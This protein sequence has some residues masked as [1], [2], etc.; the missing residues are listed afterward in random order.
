MFT[1]TRKILAA[2]IA[3]LLTVALFAA[4]PASAHVDGGYLGDVPRTSVAIQVDAE[5][6]AIY[7]YALK[8]EID[9]EKDKPVHAYGTA[10]LLY[11]NG[12]LY[13]Y[14]QVFDED[15]REPEEGKR[16]TSPWHTDSF[17][18]FINIPNNN[19]VND[20]MQYRVD[21]SGWPCVYNKVD[22]SAYGPEAVE[23][24]FTYAAKEVDGGYC[25]E[26]AI[27]VDAAGKDIGVNFQIND[28]HGA[29]RE[30][31]WAVVY[32]AA[33]KRGTNSWDVENYPYLSLGSYSEASESGLTVEATPT[34]APTADPNATEAPAKSSGKLSPAVIAAICAGVV[35]I[36]AAVVIA[37]VASKKKLK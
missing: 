9:C 28:I 24:Y 29:D 18:V 7:E 20:V 32:S 27:P 14:G 4:V 22:L 11:S 26:M 35:L 34:P 13:V 30:L 3:A 21:N 33:V 1:N 25:V 6:D 16:Q 17:E 10:W 37:I 8:V 31:T 23:G 5:K 12:T 15:V 19:N 2:V 36:A